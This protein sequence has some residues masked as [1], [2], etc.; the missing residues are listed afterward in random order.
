[1][2]VNRITINGNSYIGLF[3]IATDKF[4]IIGKNIS[5][6]KETM[7]VE[8][9][10][11]ELV[12]SSVDNSHLLGIYVV[13][14]SRGLLLP[15][16]VERSEM[17]VIRS[18]LKDVN[19]TILNTNLTALRNNI[20]TNDKI[21]IINPEFSHLEEKQIADTLGVEVVKTRIAGFSTVG[22]NN[23]L[24]NKGIVLNNRIEEEEKERIEKLVNLQGE[25]STANLGSLSI[26]LCTI[27][28]SKGL[29][30]G[31]LTTGFELARISNALGL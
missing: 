20:L 27:A 31:E 15:S 1:M 26:G 23:I 4:S 8:T 24:T 3:G 2:D 7:I 18:A 12:R 28:N 25:Q 9:L 6:L 22:A 11:T 29:L 19:I 14:N 16:M 30:L 10:G 5:K 17:E 21:A 13:A